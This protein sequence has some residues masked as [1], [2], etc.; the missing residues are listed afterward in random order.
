MFA[1]NPDFYPTPRVIARK[2]LAKITNKDAKYY[3]EPSA[4]KGDICDVIK[5]PCT[6]EEYEAECP[7]PFRKRLRY[8]TTQSPIR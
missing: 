7:M 6:F 3:L 2:M 5:N 1:D 8:G 4:G